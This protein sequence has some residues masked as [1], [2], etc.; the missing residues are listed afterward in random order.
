MSRKIEWQ[1]DKMVIC[2]TGL[3]SVAAL[4]RELEIPYSTIKKV[5]AGTFEVSPFSFRIGTSGI[6]KNLKEGRFLH[7]GEWYFLSFE[8]HE[9]VVILE[10]E[11]H[12][13][14]KVVFEHEKPESLLKEILHR[15]PQ[16]RAP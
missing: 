13:Y 12:E 7:N 14:Q 1:E 2:F 3:T 6:G 5:S 9:H 8:N 16:F 4:K 10:L 11:G 15:C